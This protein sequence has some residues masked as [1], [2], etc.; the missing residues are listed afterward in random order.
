MRGRKYEAVK[1]ILKILQNL[2]VRNHFLFLVSLVYH[3][4]SRLIEGNLQLSNLPCVH[5]QTGHVL[6][7]A[8]DIVCQ[9]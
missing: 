9:L 3:L 4:T 2:Q 7:K 8:K 1:P 5:Y 6:A